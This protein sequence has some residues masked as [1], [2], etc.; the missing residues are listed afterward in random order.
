MSV[1]DSASGDKTSVGMDET[2]GARSV[3]DRFITAWDATSRTKVPAD[4]TG[5]FAPT[6]RFYFPDGSD[7]FVPAAAALSTMVARGGAVLA[8]QRVRASFELAWVR[9]TLTAPGPTAP[10][11][12]GSAGVAAGSGIVCLKCE[13]SS[14][15][16]ATYIAEVYFLLSK[17]GVLWDDA[18]VN[19]VTGAPET[20]WSSPPPDY[21]VFPTKVTEAFIVEYMKIQFQTHD[22]GH[23]VEEA[24]DYV[25]D[26]KGVYVR[27]GWNDPRSERTMPEHIKSMKHLLGVPGVQ[28]S[29]GHWSCD[30]D[31]LVISYGFKFGL[32]K[33]APVDCQ[34]FQWYTMVP[35]PDAPKGFRVAEAHMLLVATTDGQSSTTLWPQALETIPSWRGKNAEMNAYVP[36]AKHAD[37]AAMHDSS[38][39]AGFGLP[40]IAL[41]AAAGAA[42]AYALGKQ[43]R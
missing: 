16:K 7:S 5:L 27:H 23:T 26:A 6:V 4:T 33:G 28:F 12:I 10:A 41:A 24:P 18:T 22:C 3:A 37:G 8:V 25:G 43:H 13:Y 31:T 2:L 17:P 30:G 1:W 42:V 19:V 35:A 39:H 14:A 21:A 9:A 32:V 15:R 29:L 40:T 38:G 20:G 34:A 36:E 11:G